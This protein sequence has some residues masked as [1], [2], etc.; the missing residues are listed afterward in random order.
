MAVAKLPGTFEA[1]QAQYGDLNGNLHPDLVFQDG[2]NNFLVALWIGSCFTAPALAVA[3][4]G[5]FAPGSAQLANMTGIGAP[6]LIFQDQTNHFWLTEP[7]GAN[8]A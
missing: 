1:G 8:F 6:S 3:Q 4:G 5:S 7:H 2:S